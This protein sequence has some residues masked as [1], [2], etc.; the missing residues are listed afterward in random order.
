MRCSRVGHIFR[1]SK[2]WHGSAHPVAPGIIERNRLRVANVW[3]DPAQLA[4]VDT[5][6][7][8]QN[9]DLGDL[10]P[11]RDIRRR[12]QCKSFS[13]YL[14]H[15]YPELFAPNRSNTR[16]RGRIHPPGERERCLS[17]VHREP[18]DNMPARLHKCSGART[19]RFVLTAAQDIRVMEE[20]W[21]LC[22]DANGASD[23][24]RPALLYTCHGLKGTQLW[25]VKPTDSGAV[26]LSSSGQCLGRVGGDVMMVS[27]NADETQLWVMAGDEAHRG[28][29]NSSSVPTVAADVVPAASEQS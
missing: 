15:V 11:Q 2:H 21:S 3:M 7:S 18:M 17:F 4:I 14:D 19:E 13:W 10:E 26:Q 5:F 24:Q 25:D 6:L 8:A 28:A 1:S 9:V 29:S 22:L 16:W 27:C 12:L 20:A 23:A